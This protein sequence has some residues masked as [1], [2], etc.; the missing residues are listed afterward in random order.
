MLQI[1]VPVTGALAL[2]LLGY[3]FTLRSDLRIKGAEA[4]LTIQRQAMDDV[5]QALRNFW[6][7]AA[8]LL[9]ASGGQRLQETDLLSIIDESGAILIV[10]ISRL[11]DRQLA[12]DVAD[13][14]HSIVLKV[15]SPTVLSREDVSNEHNDF[16]KLS[17]RLGAKLRELIAIH[18]V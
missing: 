10:G 2:A 14:H 3:K 11:Q 13:W 18:P 6:L 4:R 1:F 5:Q 17:N 12:D 15:A 9:M 7:A 8:R 16:I